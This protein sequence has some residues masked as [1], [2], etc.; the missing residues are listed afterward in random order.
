MV[1]RALRALTTLI[2]ATLIAVGFTVPAN[3]ASG[4]AGDV[5]AMVNQQ[6]AA[7]GLGPLVT[8]P[9]LDNAAWQWA[10]YLAATGQFMHSSSEWRS[11]MISGAGW[12]HS[13][14]NIAAGYTSASAVMAGW[15]GSAGHRANILNPNYVGVGVG[16]VSGGPYG[17][18][19]VQI[20]AASLPRVPAGNA[21]VISGSPVVGGTL[22]ATATGWP[23]GA[24]LGWLWQADGVTIPGATSATY[25]PTISDAG[26]KLTATVTGWMPGYYTSSKV[27]GPT[28]VV[29]GGPTAARLAGSDRYAT[30]VEISKN[31]FSPGVPV[32][33]LASGTDFPDAL[34]AAPAASLGGG[35]LL[36]TSPTSLPSVVAAELRRLAPARIVVVGG[37]PSVSAAV[38]S[39]L[40]T[41]APTERLSG[42]DRFETSRRI[43]DAAFESASIAYIA[44][45]LNFPDALTA[46][47]AAAKVQ[48]PVI[49]VHGGAASVDSATIGLLRA[50]GVTTVRIAGSSSTVSNGIQSSL[51][52][53]GFSVQRLA[54]SDRFETAN[55]IN[56]Q[57]FTSAPTVY[58][59][60]GVTFPDALAG[61]ALAGSRGAPLYVATGSCIPASTSL[62]LTR[63]GVSTIVLLGSSATLNSSVASFQRC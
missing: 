45:G 3:A 25:S 14:E 55:K 42:S 15:M 62:S 33:Y 63:M 9:V 37:T 16:Y 49:L 36:L 59:A 8:D 31:G 34:G 43:V 41:I 35:P 17:H 52:N 10:N 48:A 39:Q 53:N 12:I 28:A 29:S 13:G 61:A 51:A 32:V 38:F 54:G 6:R 30:A 5:F 44:T 7:A 11:S 47:A 18:Y 58:L 4:P 60:S 57:V 56:E 1:T 23:G 22:T 50:L 19:W 46:S 2:I 40:Q 27:S 20:F 26:R 24:S 21:P